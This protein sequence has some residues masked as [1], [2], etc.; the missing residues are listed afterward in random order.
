MY[1]TTPIVV[2]LIRFHVANNFKIYFVKT[3]IR[4]HPFFQRFLHNFVLPL[5]QVSLVHLAHL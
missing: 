1:T 3:K 4:Q 2:H 5:F